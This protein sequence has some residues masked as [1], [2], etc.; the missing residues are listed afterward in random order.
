MNLAIDSVGDEGPRRVVP[1]G[2]W[3]AVLDL[4][5]NWDRPE[6]GEKPVWFAATAAGHDAAQPG[7]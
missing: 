4:E 1:V 2:E 7:T 6:A 3:T 5:T